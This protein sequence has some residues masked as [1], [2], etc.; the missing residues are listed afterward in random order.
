MKIAFLIRE[1]GNT[2][3][4][5]NEAMKGINESGMKCVYSIST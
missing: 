1:D 3:V 4:L 5:L 2:D